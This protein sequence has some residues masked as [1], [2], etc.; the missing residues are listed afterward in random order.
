MF[1]SLVMLRDAN[2]EKTLTIR[3]AKRTLQQFNKLRARLCKILISSF[4]HKMDFVHN[5]SVDFF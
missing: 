3:H 5:F 1:L 2:N 4:A